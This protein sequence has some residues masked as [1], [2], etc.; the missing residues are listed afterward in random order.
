MFKAKGI[1]FDRNKAQVSRK[2]ELAL[3]E[4][5]LRLLFG[6][7]AYKVKAEV[8]YLRRAHASVHEILIIFLQNWKR[9]KLCSVRRMSIYNLGIKKIEKVL[10]NITFY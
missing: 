10:A 3:R 8:G 1:Y 5:C 7:S 6:S 4:R 9:N 2:E